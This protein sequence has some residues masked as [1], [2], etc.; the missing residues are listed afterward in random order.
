MIEEQQPEEEELYKKPTWGFK[1]YFILVAGILLIGILLGLFLYDP[2][3]GGFIPLD[4]TSPSCKYNITSVWFDSKMGSLERISTVNGLELHAVWDGTYPNWLDI[5]PHSEVTLCM[6]TENS[7]GY[8]NQSTVYN[9]IIIPCSPCINV[10]KEGK[11]IE[12]NETECEAKV[13]D[14]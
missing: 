2:E 8:C 3:N 1:E 13:G 12:L 5:F 9:K 11:V 10:T 14:N 7:T 4:I 6:E